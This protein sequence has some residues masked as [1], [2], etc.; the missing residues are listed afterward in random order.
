[1]GVAELDE[2]TGAAEFG[3][4]A[5]PVVVEFPL[6]EPIDVSMLVDADTDTPPFS[7][8]VNLVSALTIPPTWVPPKLTLH[9]ATTTKPNDAAVWIRPVRHRLWCIE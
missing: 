4:D 5:P 3:E 6:F 9:P 2:P 8:P 1:V 7:I